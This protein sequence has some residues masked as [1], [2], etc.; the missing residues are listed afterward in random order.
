MNVNAKFQGL[1]KQKLILLVGV[2]AYNVYRD[3]GKHGYETRWVN[4]AS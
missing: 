3:R 1:I 4:R 2:T